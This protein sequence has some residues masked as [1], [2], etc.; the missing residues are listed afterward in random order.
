[1]KWNKILLVMAIVIG[2]LL[3]FPYFFNVDLPE[4]SNDFKPFNNSEITY[5]EGVKIHY[6]EWNPNSDS[7]KGNVLLIHGFGGSTFSW[8]H[9]GAFLANQGYRV[10]ALD[11]PA[12]G[13]SDREYVSTKNNIS[14]TD[15]TKI[16]CNKID[17]K[18]PWIIIGH[19]MGG[20]IANFM[21]NTSPENI[22]A[23]I[24]VN[25]ASVSTK[26]STLSPVCNRLFNFPP[27]L[28]W[29]EFL[30]KNKMIKRENIYELLQSSY[31]RK[32]SEE[33]VDGYFKPLNQKG[34]PKAIINSFVY[35]NKNDNYKL[36]N[37]EK[38]KTLIIGGENDEIIS[39][40]VAYE[41]NKDIKNSELH[42]IKNAGHCPMET[43]QEEFHHIISNFLNQLNNQNQY[44]L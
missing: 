36:E 2:L 41:I 44:K 25:G 10:I 34:T 1:M 33:E 27:T 39:V 30:G 14:R 22:S 8:R 12:F 20:A 40:K 16:L 3:S 7:I 6:Q 26:K 19:S 43:H 4:I 28:R 5:I 37:F 38:F 31:G 24:I 35:S 15:L 21:T 13:Y 32:P 17:D 29:I 42:I 18:N 23:L 11:L 9:T